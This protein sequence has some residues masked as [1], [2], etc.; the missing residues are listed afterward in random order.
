VNATVGTTSSTRVDHVSGR[1]RRLDGLRALAAVAVI[2][3]HTGDWTDFVR[4]PLAPWVQEL[5]AG[6]AVFFVIS[7]V[8]LYAPF[9]AA[10]LDGHPPPNLRTYVTRR[11]TRIYP[12]YWV[13]LL[14]IVP[15]SPIL[16]MR[17]TWQWFS[18]PLL[19]H[20]Y[21]IA[22]AASDVGLRQSWTLVVEVSFYA[23]LPLYAIG[24]RRLGRRVGARR[25][26]VAAA[27]S[28]LV[29]GPIF[30]LVSMRESPV[31]LPYPLRILPPTLGIFA[32]GM[33]LAIAREAV[34]RRPEPPPWWKRLGASAVPWFA[35]A[36]IAYAV[37]CVGVGI[38]PT[39]PFSITWIQQFEQLLLQTLIAGCVVAPAVIVPAGRSPAL[40]AIASRPLAFV[41]M[42]SY[43]IYL[44]HYAVIEWLVRRVGCN[45]SGLASCPADVHWS[46]VKVALAAVP[47]SIAAGALSWYLVER[48]MIRIAHRYYAPRSVSASRPV[49]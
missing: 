41:G 30:H 5:N 39:T 34:A 29:A 18:V 27:L 44:W 4:G 22:G 33:L 49:A 28:L 40:R 1:D 47:L 12:A 31:R 9:V 38:E 35:V 45:P 21:R 20:T 37:L 17:G 7:A 10:H 26:E 6:V 3:T 36:G 48:P 16:R 13:A 25:A 14:I 46:F 11:V 24:V 19:V 43:G 8:L 42:L 2:L 15:L 23:F 32:C